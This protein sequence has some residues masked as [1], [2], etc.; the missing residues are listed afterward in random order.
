[1]SP[2]A[3]ARG[4]CRDHLLDSTEEVILRAGLGS[5]TL[6]AVAAH[7]KVSKGGLLYHFPSKD[8]LI[9]GLVE[10]A[11]GRWR[12]DY[13][14][15]IAAEPPGRGRV[16]RAILRLSLGSRESCYETCRRSSI[17]LVAAIATNPALTEPLRR[18]HS[19]LLSRIREDGGDTGVGEAVVLAANGMWFEQVFGLRDLPASR[20]ES[21]RGALAALIETDAGRSPTT[22]RVKAPPTRSRP[23]K[24]QHKQKQSTR[25]PARPVAKR[26][27]KP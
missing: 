27:I 9:L 3:F 2:P 17:V 19:E 24:D 18:V 21:I 7:A 14:E 4:A 13:S 5:L 15:A 23:P 12:S 10:R 22:K 16:A 6:D 11:C 25:R 1:M 20:V 26:G 8:A